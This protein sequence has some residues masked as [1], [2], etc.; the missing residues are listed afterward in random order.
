MHAGVVKNLFGLPV[1]KELPA[2]TLKDMRI[3]I[4]GASGHMLGQHGTM[5]KASIEASRR[6]R[7]RHNLEDP[8]GGDCWCKGLDP[9]TLEVSSAFALD[10]F[11]EAHRLEPP[12][13]PSCATDVFATS[14]AQCN[15]LHQ[16]ACCYS[17]CLQRAP[18]ACMQSAHVQPETVTSSA[19]PLSCIGFMLANAMQVDPTYSGHSDDVPVSELIDGK[20]VSVFKVMKVF[21]DAQL[22][23]SILQQLRGGLADNLVENYHSRRARLCDKNVN[24]T[25]GHRFR[26]SCAVATLRH[27]GKGSLDQCIALADGL[28]M[29]MGPVAREHWARKDKAQATDSERNRRHDVKAKRKLLKRGKGNKEPGDIRYDMHVALRDAGVRDEAVLR[30]QA[31]L[32]KLRKHAADQEAALATH[33]A[34]KATCAQ[35]KDTKGAT[36]AQNRIRNAQKKVQE[37][38]AAAADVEARMAERKERCDAR[39]A[40]P[41]YRGRGGAIRGAARVR[42]NLNDC[43]VDA[44]SEPSS[45]GASTSG[46]AVAGPSERTTATASR[47]VATPGGTG[48]RARQRAPAGGSQALP[49]PQPKRSRRGGATGSSRN[50]PSPAVGRPGSRPTRAAAAAQRSQQL[51]KLR[52]SDDEA[53]SS[54]DS[55]ESSEEEEEE[56]CG[57][58]SE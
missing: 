35:A 20:H 30:N 29:R 37:L 22:S 10:E 33:R 6:I 46:G 3:I 9:D 39:A 49:E 32:D 24:V 15:V 52:D 1:N 44:D 18:V 19:V 17:S 7:Q 8:K 55:G 5:C 14:Y 36:N 4:D 16:M 27:N 41:G 2:A 34:A 43:L 26:N 54:D 25:G 56:Y 40:Q 47:A 11:L 38:T 21:T 57:S 28:G 13:S 48:K 45:A 50:G 58:E 12:F 51:K 42:I 23:D 53:M 31:E